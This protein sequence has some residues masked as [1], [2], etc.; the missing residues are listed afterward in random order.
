MMFNRYVMG[1]EFE[2]YDSAYNFRGNKQREKLHPNIEEE[3]KNEI[4]RSSLT[5]HLMNQNTLL[6]IFV[7]FMI[8]TPIGLYGTNF[9]VKKMPNMILEII[10][11]LFNIKF[12]FNVVNPSVMNKI[13]QINYHNIE[14]HYQ[15]VVLVPKLLYE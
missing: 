10:E 4:T 9:G 1:V 14:K 3:G 11:N 12:V 6:K 8:F 15:T 13:I 7:K 5:R 2:Q